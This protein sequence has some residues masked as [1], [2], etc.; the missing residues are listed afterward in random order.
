MS[1]AIGPRIDR[2]R[3]FQIE[4]TM[5]ADKAAAREAT[6]R[7]RGLA[8][9]ARELRREID[10]I[11]RQG[12]ALTAS[13]SRE[14]ADAISSRNGRVQA[15]QPKI[16]AASQECEAARQRAE[17]SRELWKRCREYAGLEVA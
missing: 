1:R 13:A 14:Q 6:E 16:D 5:L 3:I 7:V 4:Q 8:D 12:Y 17:A 15:L 2:G 11:E 9:Q 10:R